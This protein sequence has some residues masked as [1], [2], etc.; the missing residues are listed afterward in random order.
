MAGEAFGERIEKRHVC[1]IDIVIEIYMTVRNLA[2][3][4]SRGLQ[5]AR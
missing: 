3:L 2:A 4:P 5:P 1:I